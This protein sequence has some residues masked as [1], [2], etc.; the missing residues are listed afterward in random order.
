MPR[1]R[2]KDPPN[3]T[4]VRQVELAPLN[5][6][7]AVSMLGWVKQPE[8]AANLGLRST[9][10]LDKTIKWI[11]AAKRSD[12]CRAFAILVQ[13]RYI[14]NVVLDQ[15]DTF[16]RCARLSVYIGA[17]DQRGRGFGTQAC[18]LAIEVAFRDLNLNKV[19]LLVHQ[20]NENAIR[21]YSK[22]GFQIEGVHRQAFRFEGKL[23]AAL[24]MGLLREDVVPSRPQRRV[25]R[26]TG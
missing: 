26:S 21:S 8:L 14:G 19:W 15:I 13:R 18:R 5:S 23:I 1:S 11:R 24:Y 22:I 9:P 20:R 6:R 7:H 10:T 2:K 12:T 4:P 25:A 17:T 3:I 16:L